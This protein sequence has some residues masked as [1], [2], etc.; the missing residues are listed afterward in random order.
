MIVL[1]TNQLKHVA[2]P[3]GAVLGM[4]RK[5]AA[6]HDRQL[7]LPEMVAIEH[8]AHHRH[9]TDLALI[10][11]GKALS[12]LGKTF[13]RDLSGAVTGLQLDDAARH[14]RASLEG[15]FAILPTPAGAADEALRREAN[16][17]P[18]AQQQW[19]DSKGNE[20]AARGARDVAI[21]LTLLETASRTE[22][23]I[24]F[25][26]LDQD[27][28]KDDFHVSLREEATRVLGARAG[29]LRLVDGGIDQLLRELATKVATPPDLESLLN[30]PVA[31]HAVVISQVG[32]LTAQ[33]LHHVIPMHAAIHASTFHL[34][35]HEIKRSSAYAVGDSTWV[36]VQLIW[37]GFRV[38]HSSD[39]DGPDWD[40][41]A[42]M[43]IETTILLEVQGGM[44]HS[45]EVMA[46][47][48]PVSLGPGEPQLGGVGWTVTIPTR[49][50]EFHTPD[51]AGW[52]VIT[53]HADDTPPPQAG[54]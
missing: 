39:S 42:R 45:A 21:W 16:R 9:E 33:L 48:P 10:S 1:D 17:M 52:A 37:R 26:T 11:A 51:G 46:S 44:V 43:S 32:G 30:S 24:W 12:V 3:H 28:G 31:N 14:R 18:P 19:H 34:S 27:F 6:L 25:V 13:D 53:P 35:P 29:Q 36:S 38:L 7:A 15:V 47:A 40:H 41:P 54:L 8:V 20:L 50:T 2:F 4:L 23:E 22:E 5:I 49:R